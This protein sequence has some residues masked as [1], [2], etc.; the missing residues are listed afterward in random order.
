[1]RRAPLG[2]LVIQ[3]RI[4]LRLHPEERFAALCHIDGADCGYYDVSISVDGL[5]QRHR[6]A[7]RKLYC[8]RRAVVAGPPRRRG[9]GCDL[10][11]M[12]G[13]AAGLACCRLSECR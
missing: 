3:T 5:V 12:V 1:M 2:L 9:G 13:F 8:R 4:A 11:T 10:S 7:V 6:I